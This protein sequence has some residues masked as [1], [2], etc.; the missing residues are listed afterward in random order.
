[1]PSWKV[2]V[3]PERAQRGRDLLFADDRERKRISPTSVNAQRFPATNVNSQFYITTPPWAPI[4]SPLVLKEDLSSRQRYGRRPW[5]T[6]HL[7]LSLA[8]QAT[9]S[10]TSSIWPRRCSAVAMSFTVCRAAL[11]GT[12]SVAVAPTKTQL[13]VQRYLTASSF[14]HVRVRLSMPA[15]DKE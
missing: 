8:T 11:S 1:M 5:N 15:L 10:A 7:L 2:C 14:A 9:T 12:S 6:H 13:T 3:H 4:V